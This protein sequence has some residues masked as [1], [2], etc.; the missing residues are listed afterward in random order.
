MALNQYKFLCIE[1]YKYLCAGLTFERVHF[2]STQPALVFD[3]CNPI[4]YFL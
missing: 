2:N 4:G 3:L 1:K